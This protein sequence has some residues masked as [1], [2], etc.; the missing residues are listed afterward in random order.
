MIATRSTDLNQ[1]F[2]PVP[3]IGQDIDL[4]RDGQYKGFDDLLSQGNFG[5][6][7]AAPPRSLR[8]IQF[9]PQGEKKLF[10]EQGREDPLMA[11]DVGHVLSMILMPT[12]TGKL[13]ASLLSQRVIH[14]KKQDIPGGNPQRLK[15]L[16][17]GDL[18]SLLD[19]PNVFSKEAR[20]TA[21]RMAQE[22][23]SQGLHHGGCMGF[24][25]QLDKTD[26]KARKDSE[27]R[28]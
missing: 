20:E 12:T 23:A 7:G 25:A 9:G 8:M 10:A 27:R 15:E 28:S 19:S 16:I 1:G 11:K 22:R 6:K 14:D 26:D 17:Q 5:V 4:T 24:F 13:L 21:E 2:G 3:A 18:Q